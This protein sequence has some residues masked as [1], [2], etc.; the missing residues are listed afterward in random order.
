MY[1]LT[2]TRGDILPDGLD[3]SLSAGDYC[4]ASVEKPYPS[5]LQR[6]GHHRTTS[7]VSNFD[8]LKA[9]FGLR[10]ST[11][12]SIEG[13]RNFKNP[14]RITKLQAGHQNPNLPLEAG[15][16]IPQCNECNQA[17]RD[18]F[19]FDGSGRVI[20]INIDAPRWQKKY[21]LV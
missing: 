13:D 1:I 2:G 19:V 18:W 12:G 6:S 10:C 16:I 5:R 3:V 4:L 20:D 15:N 11:C 9:Q 14:S 8:E 7:K 17:Y 21:K